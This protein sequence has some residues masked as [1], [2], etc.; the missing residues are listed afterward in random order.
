M[1]GWVFHNIA[2]GI[3]A[4]NLNMDITSACDAS[5]DHRPLGMKG[6]LESASHVLNH[7][8][9]H[10]TNRWASNNANMPFWGTIGLAPGQ[11]ILTQSEATKMDQVPNVVGM[12]ARDA[13]YEMER[14]GLKTRVQGRG[15]VVAQS[16][17]AGGKVVKG[18]M[19]LLKMQYQ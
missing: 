9:F 11:Y 10:T 8:G 19:C 7:F 2:E 12:G 18:S 14:R 6:N 16:I 4:H 15:K 13:V 5:Q 1:S 17:D 3:M